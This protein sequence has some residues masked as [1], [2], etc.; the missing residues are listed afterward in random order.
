MV[1]APG[2]EGGGGGVRREE[3]W[4][5]E[6]CPDGLGCRGPCAPSE[7]ELPKRPGRCSRCDQRQRATPAP[8][9]VSVSGLPNSCL[10]HRVTV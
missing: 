8:R 4:E 1:A 5:N 3:T 2:G 6:V 7:A 10:N 9:W